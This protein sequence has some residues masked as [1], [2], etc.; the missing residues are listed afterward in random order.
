MT[1][2][3]FTTTSEARASDLEVDVTSPRRFWLHSPFPQL[4][5]TTIYAVLAVL[6]FE[7]VAP[8]SNSAIP[9]GPLSGG[10]SINDPTLMA[11]FLSW[12]AFALTHGH[13]IF[14]TNYVFSAQGT[15]LFPYTSIPLLGALATPITLKLGPVAALNVL[16]RLAVAGSAT[17]MFLVLSSWC[18]RPYAFMGGLLFGFSPY[19]IMQSENHLNLAFLMLL[20]PIVWCVTEIIVIRRRSAV[21]LG[22]TL[23]IL[24]A[25]Q[26]YVSLEMLALIGIVVGVGT[27]AYVAINHSQISA[28]RGYWIRGLGAGAATFV[29]LTGY[30]LFNFLFGPGHLHG[31]ILA[32]AELQ[33]FHAD[34]LGP[35]IPTANQLVTTPKLTQLSS[36][37]VVGNVTENGAYLGI[38]LLATLVYFAVRFRARPRITG[39]FALMMF[40]LILSLGDRITVAS[41]NVTVP[42][43]EMILR[44]LPLVNSVVPARFAAIV[45]LFAAVTLALGTQQFFDTRRRLGPGLRA[46]RWVVLGVGLATL[47]TLVPAVPVTANPLATPP[48]LSAQLA[49]IP[50]GAEVLTYPFPVYNWT[51]PMLWQ[52]EDRMRFRLIGGYIRPTNPPFLEPAS[53]PNFFIGA[54]YGSIQSFLS[55]TPMTTNVAALRKYLILAH[56]GAV[57]FQ[58]VGANPSVVRH[59]LVATL[60]SPTRQVGNAFAI[61]VLP[62]AH[63]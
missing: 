27:I 14:F 57:I 11:W 62:S 9:L 6:V 24:A 52:A 43:P 28:H 51:S 1:R 40:A 36:H 30:F 7:P 16:V 42:M 53:V 50:R 20:P 8:W 17:S 39:P 48:S 33:S 35:I 18:R 10:F 4:L 47:V 25:L 12:N 55:T 19:L 29:I 54:A 45:A 15:S 41:H 46:P 23:G 2:E 21:T 22:I 60:G 3:V 49:V 5:A 44:Y 63:R 32:T 26:I 61:W 56:V 37:F 38:P 31:P 13:N 34:F 58:S 59:L